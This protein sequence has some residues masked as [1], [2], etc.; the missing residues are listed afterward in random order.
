MHVAPRRRF[1]RAL[2][3]ALIACALA[4]P[5]SALPL[6]TIFLVGLKS[7]AVLCDTGESCR[8]GRCVSDGS[9]ACTAAAD[10]PGC[11]VVENE[12][13]AMCRPL[14][15][16]P[17]GTAC[18]WSLFFDGSEAGLDAPVRALDVLPDGSLVLR[19]AADNGVPDIAGVDRTDLVRFL[20]KDE[21]G[22]PIP[23]DLPYRLGE[24]ELFFD[25]GAVERSSGGRLIE[26]VSVLANACRD[27]N[28][29]GR[30]DY[31]ECDLV[32][33]PV[34]GGNLA[35]LDIEIED[36]VRCRPT[37]LSEGGTIDAC[38]YD[39]F[40]DASEVNDTQFGDGLSEA[41]PGSWTTGGTD[42]FAVLDYDPLQHTATLV[43]SA[44]N[45]ST[46]P[47]HQPSRD[48][49]AQTAHLG[50]AGWCDDEAGLRCLG[51]SDCAVG[52]ACGHDSNPQANGDTLLVFDGSNALGGE[53]LAAIAVLP[54]L[55]ADGVPDPIDNC[56]ERANPPHCSGSGEVCTTNLDCP[57]GESCRQADADGDGV[58]DPC[59]RCQARDDAVCF[60]GDFVTDLPSEQCD[61]GL[62]PSGGYN[63]AGDS[64]CTS[65][66]RIIGRCTRSGA[67]CVRAADCPDH[68]AGEG[69]CGN[70]AVEGTDE[71]CDDA[72]G[73][74][75]DACGNQC[76]EV[77][78]PIPLPSEC[79]GLIGP[80]IVPTFVRT[81]RFQKQ[82]RVVVADE[83]PDHY[84]KWSTRGEFSL[85][86]GLRFD[87]D[88]QPA[89]LIFNQGE[90]RCR[91]GAAEGAACAVAA[92]CPGGRCSATL[93]RAEL[94][95]GWFTQA[96]QAADRPRWTFAD[97]AGT[98]DGAPAW[99][100]GKFA[101]RLA[102]IRRPLNEIKFVLQGRG[103][104]LDP[105][106]SL[107]LD[108]KAMGGPPTRVRQTIVIGDLCTTQTLQC[109]PNFAGTTLQ[110]YSRSD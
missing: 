110:C 68:A 13:V 5:A 3:L 29:D 11:L 25:G 15:L 71:E 72:N 41:R 90:A 38:A 88:T 82:R 74:D 80:R 63:G 66:C 61:L 43:F 19:A 79:E 45:T 52:G 46:L 64:P 104:R 108:P 102:T 32:F 77:D 2:R 67:A 92:D 76:R 50:P 6:S 23:M 99:T 55:D 10:C 37:A 7:R 98:I 59:D 105:Q 103:D 56:R 53:M 62:V 26:A 22:R 16:G 4:A 42:S 40:Y 58:G 18:D 27:V 81:L 100:K 60:C 39:L 1:A 97:R 69:C 89:E 36:L 54:D 49:L 95:A 83:H 20:P 44:G 14:G 33:S 12:D 57:A 65:D 78:R 107:H 91:G 21:R 47:A 86:P 70:A 24:W 96:G 84:S 28:D 51:D 93:Y 8:D 73:I 30:V 17:G 109:E 94:A 87:P 31:R 75:D 106:L 48:L 101:Q 9:V 34:A 35:G 85:V